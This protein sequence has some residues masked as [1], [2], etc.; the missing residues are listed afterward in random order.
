MKNNIEENNGC[1]YREIMYVWRNGY[2]IGPR[3]YEHYCISIWK[4]ACKKISSP[5]GF[6]P[7]NNVEF[8]CAC[9]INISRQSAI[10]RLPH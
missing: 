7:H 3:S 8:T 6:E 1:K 5:T 9:H 10:V 2:R 4:K